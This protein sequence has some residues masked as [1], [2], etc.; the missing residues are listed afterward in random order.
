MAKK[1][2]CGCVHYTERGRELVKLCALHLEEAEQR[3]RNSLLTGWAQ[4]SNAHSVGTMFD[5]AL[6]VDPPR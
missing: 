6:Q 4:D 5:R 3:H 2:S 1:D